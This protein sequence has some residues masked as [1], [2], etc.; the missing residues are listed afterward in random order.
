[1]KPKIKFRSF[2]NPDHLR[3]FPELESREELCR[4]R[5][6]FAAAALQGLIYSLSSHEPDE[7]ASIAYAFADGMM[8]QRKPSPSEAYLRA[9]ELRHGK[10]T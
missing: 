4:I 3:G 1:V 5:D 6:T 7:V 10:K 9:E 2:Q 8:R